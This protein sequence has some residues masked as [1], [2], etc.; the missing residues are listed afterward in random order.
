MEVK[1]SCTGWL[2]F[3]CHDPWTDFRQNLHV[4]FLILVITVYM[5][6]IFYTAV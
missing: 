4:L 3:V 1:G 5:V 6:S 2:H